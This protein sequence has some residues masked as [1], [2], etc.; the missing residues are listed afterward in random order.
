MMFVELLVEAYHRFHPTSTLTLCCF[1]KLAS[2]VSHLLVM[3]ERWG[4]ELFTGF[5]QQVACAASLRAAD[6]H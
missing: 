1:Y 5:D 4:I 2:T 6:L 3:S